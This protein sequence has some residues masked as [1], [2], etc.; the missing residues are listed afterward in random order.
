MNTTT[1]GQKNRKPLVIVLAVCGAVLAV[2]LLALFALQAFNSSKN[3]LQDYPDVTVSGEGVK[4]LNVD[5]SVYDV[6][7]DC[8]DPDSDSAD[9]FVLTQKRVLTESSLKQRGDTLYLT[10]DVEPFSFSGPF[11]SPKPVELTIPA[12]HCDN[13]T[14]ASLDAV[15]HAGAGVINATGNF[16]QLETHIETGV[17]KVRGAA[18]NVDAQIGAGEIDLRLQDVETADIRVGSGTMRGD[19]TGKTPTNIVA[20]VQAG[21][22]NLGLPEGNYQTD[23]DTGVGDVTND[24]RDSVDGDVGKITVNVSVGDVKLYNVVR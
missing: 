22:L 1:A 12:K 24:L 2:L 9:D 17:V 23:V 13:N 21:E 8:A 3:R 7:I 11:S 5:V 16:K 15:F 18:A 6:I 10:H 4:K 19:F 20:D 14:P